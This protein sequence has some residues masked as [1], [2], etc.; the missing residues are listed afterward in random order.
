M[1]LT[2]LDLIEKFSN[3]TGVE[4]TSARA[5][6]ICFV[7]RQYHRSILQSNITLLTRNHTYRT[8]YT[9]NV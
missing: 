1:N 8:R 2:I 9:R 5:F 7:G 3:K 6:R 4:W